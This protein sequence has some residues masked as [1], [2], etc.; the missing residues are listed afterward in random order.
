MKAKELEKIQEIL[1]KHSKEIAEK[2]WAPQLQGWKFWIVGEIGT[3][4][5]STSDYLSQNTKPN[6]ANYGINE[7]IVEMK[8]ISDLDD[9]EAGAEV[10]AISEW[11]YTEKFMG[12]NEIAPYFPSR[13]EE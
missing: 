12:I 6:P 1:L 4:K 3:E 11:L 10:D 7:W 5:F 2:L 9:I 13:K 8:V